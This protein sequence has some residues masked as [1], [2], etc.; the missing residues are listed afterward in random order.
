MGNLV[1]LARELRKRSTKTERKIW[2]WLRRGNL[3]GFKFRRQ[4]PIGP[5]ILDFYC[6]ELKLCIELDGAMHTT[7]TGAIRDEIRTRQLEEAG[8]TVLRL[9]NDY[10]KEQPDGCWDLIVA[11][12]ERLKERD[13]SP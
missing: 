4:H 8:I 3:R 1:P 2:F 13:P 5:Y 11:T 10:V 9:W 7:T 6:P 12:V